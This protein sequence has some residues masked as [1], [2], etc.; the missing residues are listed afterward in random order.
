MHA[1]MRVRREHGVFITAITGLL[2]YAILR[3][4]STDLDIRVSHH[5]HPSAPYQ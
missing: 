5:I 1:Y 2:C 4:S 3:W